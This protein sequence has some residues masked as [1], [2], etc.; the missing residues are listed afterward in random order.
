MS[1]VADSKKY[2]AEL[3]AVVFGFVSLTGAVIRSW[4][5]HPIL[6]P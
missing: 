6:L 3:V 4:N 1:E 2:A 5:N